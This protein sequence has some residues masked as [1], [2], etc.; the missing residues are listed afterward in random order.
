MLAER[1]SRYNPRMAQVKPGNDVVQPKVRKAFPDTAFWASDVK[2]DAQGHAKVTMTF[3]DSLTTWRATVRA[4][5]T[6]SKAGSQINRVIVRKNVIVR[7][8]TPRFMRKGD[9]ITIPVI[10]HNYL[11][12]AKQISLQ[13]EVHGLDVVAGSPQTITVPSKGDGEVLWRLKA[14]RIGTATLLA[15]ALTNEESD[16]LEITFP[17]E[18]SG[19]PVTIG[20]NSAIDQPNGSAQTPV[21]FPANTDPAAHGLHVE[22]SP[23][24]AGSI[25][26]ALAYL[27]SYPYGCTE[28]T[29][30]S[31]LPNVIV[32]ETMKKLNV[33]GRVDENDLKA[34]MQT[35]LDRLKDYQHDDGGWGWWKEDGSRVFMTAYVVSGLAE[36]SRSMELDVA[37]R[38]MKQNGVAYLEKQLKDHPR[39]LPELRAYTV[40]ALIEA[41]QRSHGGDL[42]ALYGRAKDLS[43]EGLSMLGLAMID[44]KDARA[45]AVAKLVESKVKRQGELASWPSRY[46]P[47]L[48]FEYDNSAEST[49]YALRFLTKADPQSPLLDAAAQWLVL[50]RTG[51]Y[52]W[53]STA[54]TAMVL[55]GLVDYMA[56]SKELNA[57]FDVDVLVNGASVAKR[58]FTAADATSGAGLSVDLPAEKLQPA[59]NSVQIV[60]QG[61]GKAYWAVQGRYFSTEKR[62]YQ[63]GTVNLNLT[64]DYFKLTPTVKDGKVVYQLQALR[65]SAQVGDVLAVHLAVNGSP[66]KYLLIE[67][68]IPAGT[69]F[70]QNEDS[71]NIV[72]RPGNWEWWYTRR[73]FHDDRAAMFATEFEGR[74]ESFYLL[75][76]VNP[77]TFAVSPAHVEPMYQPGVQ[78]TT[79]EL[80]LQADPAPDASAAQGVHP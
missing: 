80:R 4:V 52:W 57:D 61:A 30:S 32:A 40:Y 24:I 77:G 73:E 62:L 76:V 8:G 75:K 58:H 37:S 38:G 21:S 51:G 34:K 43:A 36:A 18:P 13:L 6:D 49:A 46:S 45:S 41:G 22:I 53:D 19:V 67:D 79:E 26:P 23:S 17:V 2:T 78:A 25:F 27:T 70:V 11:D 16:A 29:M 7:M 14:S 3:P 68:P 15:K 28:Q 56:A 64:R 65:G 54:Q 12:T 10:A 69:E 74:H 71:Y 20:G 59:N 5:T 60:K 35:G 48:D 63:T 72:D 42:D 44:A 47:L 50:N 39:M 9:E 66:M 31:F 55:F 1:R 33:S